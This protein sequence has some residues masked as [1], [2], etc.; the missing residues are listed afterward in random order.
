MRI[1]EVKKILCVLFV[2]G[3]FV[4]IIY[5]NLFARS[6]VFSLGIFSDYFLEQYSNKA[7]NENAYIWYIIKLRVFPVILLLLPANINLRKIIA[8]IVLLWTGFSSG[9]ILTTAVIK[10]GMKGIGLCFVGSMPHFIC[11]IAAYCIILISIFV[12]P[13]VKWDKTKTISMILSI[14]FGVVAEVYINPVLMDIYLNIL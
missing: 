10:L 2:L 3:F 14:L 13:G 9:L 12:Y 6:W 8:M 11:Y 7:L 5:L 4:G 1:Q